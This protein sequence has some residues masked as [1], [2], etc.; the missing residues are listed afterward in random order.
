MELSEQ[1]KNWLDA[2]IE[3]FNTG[4]FWHAH[5]DWEELWKSLKPNASQE[6]IDGVQ[7][8]IQIAAMLLN[9]Q[10]RKVRGVTN[11]WTKASAKLEPVKEG[12]F[13]IDIEKLSEDCEPFHRDVEKFTL[14]ALTVC[15]QRQS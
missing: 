1:Q 4:R 8:I 7:G 2:G 9:H 13:G 5:E 10:R 15:I 11:L 12:L 14:D 3:N 6:L